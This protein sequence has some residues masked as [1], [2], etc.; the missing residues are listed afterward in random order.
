V[1]APDRVPG[2]ALRAGRLSGLS[3]GAGVGSRHALATARRAV[4]AALPSD[5]HRRQGRRAADEPRQPEL[6]ARAIARLDVRPGDRVLDLGF[7]GGL[8]FAPLWQRGARVVGIDRAED[9][10]A[11]AR[12]R[13][14]DA[15]ADGRLELHAGDVGR[16]PLV[17][18]AVDRVLTVNTVYFWADL[19]AAFGELRRVLAPGGRLVV[20]IRDLAV[21]QQLDP[22]VFTLRGPDELASA[23]RTAGFADAEVD[24]A[25]NGKTHLIV[26]S[27]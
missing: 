15:V 9:M 27:R 3:H 6:N 4:A 13:F 8:T 14:A 24:T 19:G 12:A 1:I 17:D 11:A 10:V 18:G 26:A 7:G 25:R 16:L 5:R 23:V 2:G 22:V 21:M 20:A